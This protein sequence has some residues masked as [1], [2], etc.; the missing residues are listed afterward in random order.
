MRHNT[1]VAE[2]GK[3]K[4][5]SKKKK[6]EKKEWGKQK[7]VCT[8]H[9]F[10]EGSFENGL[11]LLS[12]VIKDVRTIMYLVCLVVLE[13]LKSVVL[14]SMETASTL[15]RLIARPSVRRPCAF[16]QSP[17]CK[18]RDLDHGLALHAHIEIVCI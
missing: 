10:Q 3:K 11:I 1:R 12:R 15:P 8:L 5:K 2:V 4:K 6:N 7:R 18:S 14:K 16:N 17:E 9:Y 13:C